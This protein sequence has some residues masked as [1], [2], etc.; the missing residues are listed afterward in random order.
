MKR[1]FF[2]AG[3]PSVGKTTAL[4]RTLQSLPYTTGFYSEPISENGQRTGLAAVISN[5]E[6]IPLATAIQNGRNKKYLLN[7]HQM[8]RV[9]ERVFS[10]KDDSAIAY[11]D[12]IGTLYC[13]SP[14]FVECVRS[15]LGSRRM[16]GTITRRGHA[17]IEEIYRR[18]DCEV[19]EV[20]EANRDSIPQ[21]IL[22]HMSLN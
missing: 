12:P 2:L 4:L 11:V 19:L 8:D 14:S 1:H 13:Q 5:G 22:S 3:L 6:R 16:I 18:A 21:M 7:A 20:T 17:L 10:V 9:L 15:I